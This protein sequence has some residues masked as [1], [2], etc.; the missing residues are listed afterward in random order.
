MTFETFLTLLEGI[1]AGA[2]PGLIA[3]LIGVAGNRWVRAALSILPDLVG[4]VRRF[5]GL[6][7]A[8]GAPNV[9]PL[10][11]LLALLLLGC[12]GSQHPQLPP[13]KV[14]LCLVRLNDRL[15]GQTSCDAIVKS[16]ASVVAEDNECSDL[17]LHG[18]KCEAVAAA[19]RD[20]G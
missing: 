1:A 11:V 7:G 9:P 12:G 10:P 16:I 5:K 13:D 2:V 18:L 14:A 20:G 4:M 15:A 6:A 19:G 3:H 8:P 17:L